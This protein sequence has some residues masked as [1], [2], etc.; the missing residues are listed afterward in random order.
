MMWKLVLLSQFSRFHLVVIN[1][2]I[3]LLM[4]RRNLVEQHYLKLVRMGGEISR[5][6]K[7]CDLL[8]AHLQ[9]KI[10]I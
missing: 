1:R 5:N 4:G 2:I 7:L 9:R 8:K 3:R 6:L 10:S